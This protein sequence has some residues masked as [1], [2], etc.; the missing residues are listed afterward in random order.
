MKRT[1]AALLMA[2]FLPGAVS[3]LIYGGLVIMLAKTRKNFGPPV[4]GFTWKS[5][6]RFSSD[7]LRATLSTV[8]AKSLT[9][10]RVQSAQLSRRFDTP[11]PSSSSRGLLHFTLFLV[12][13]PAPF[14]LPTA[15]R[16]LNLDWRLRNPRQLLKQM[17]A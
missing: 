7:A 17:D 12:F 13:V 14:S 5:K 4:T 15:K 2:G 9:F 3:A 10:S 8:V 16:S 1:L 6:G 11:S